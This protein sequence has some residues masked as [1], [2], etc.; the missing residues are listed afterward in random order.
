MCPRSPLH[1]VCWLCEPCPRHARACASQSHGFWCPHFILMWAA[2]ALWEAP[3][4]PCLE[5]GRLRLYCDE[6]RN[7][8]VST[9]FCAPSC[10]KCNSYT[11]D[12]EKGPAAPA[13]DTIAWAED[14]THRKQN[15]FPTRS[16]EAELPLILPRGRGCG[17]GVC[18]YQ[19]QVSRSHTPNSRMPLCEGPT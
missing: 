11:A 9:E 18:I 7:S 15:N 14:A 10:A 4:C 13:C 16:T 17:G 8:P 12:P 3:L 6:N 5:A 1:C 2:G 19:I